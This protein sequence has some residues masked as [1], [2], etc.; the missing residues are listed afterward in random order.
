MRC[1][2]ERGCHGAMSTDCPH[3]AT[4]V[5]PRTCIYTI[6]ERQWYD[7]VD[8]MEMLDAYDV[9]FSATRKENCHN[10]RFFL[11]RAPRIAM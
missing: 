7:R 5:C 6:C 10:C 3:D 4:G 9:D 8:A 11:A 2:E 1:W